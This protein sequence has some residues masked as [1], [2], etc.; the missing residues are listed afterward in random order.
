MKQLLLAL[1]IGVLS[2]GTQ[3]TVLADAWQKIAQKDG[4][5]IS[6]FSQN[7][8][9]SM[10]AT[11]VNQVY[12][13]LDGGSRWTK[14]TQPSSRVDFTYQVHTT[15]DSINREAII[16]LAIKAGK[17]DS[18]YRSR[19]SGESWEIMDWVKDSIGGK[20]P[21]QVFTS[22]F[23]LLYIS[24]FDAVSK[25][26][27]LY[28]SRDNGN[29]F[30]LV[31]TSQKS[32]V[33]ISGYYEAQDSSKYIYSSA[34]VVRIPTNGNRTNTDKNIISLTT[35]QN[36]SGSPVVV[37]AVERTPA[38]SIIRSNNNG[39]SW[40]P[41][42]T[43]LPLDSMKRLV[44]LASGRDGEVYLFFMSN[45]DSTYIYKLGAG[46]SNWQD[47]T[48]LN[49]SFSGVQSL[50]S[51][52]YLMFGKDG[53]FLGEEGA[54]TWTSSSTGIQA[55][56]LYLAAS[57]DQSSIVSC[58]KSGNIYTTLTTTGTWG[59]ST[60]PLALNTNEDITGIA[61]STKG[62]VMLS[63]KTRGIMVSNDRGFSFVQGKLRS[64]NQ[65]FDGKTGGL[66]SNSS[67]TYFVI[68]QNGFLSSSDGGQTWDLIDD[69]PQWN[70]LVITSMFS[71]D[72]STFLLGTSNGV[73]Q[74]NTQS[75]EL[76][77]IGL[78]GVNATIGVDSDGTI[79]AGTTNNEK[80]RL[81]IHRKRKADASFSEVTSVQ[82]NPDMP[83]Q[84]VVTKAGN[85]YINTGISFVVLPTNATSVTPIR[86]SLQDE[87]VTYVGLETN[88]TL[89]TATALGGVYI[90]TTTVPSS[91]DEDVLP[92][93][94]MSIIPNPVSGICSIQTPEQV[95]SITISSVTGIGTVLNLPVNTTT[96]TTSQLN[97]VQ[98]DVSTLQS[99]VYT[100]TVATKR[101][102]I[103]K[104]FVISR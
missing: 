10:Y 15:I 20:T 64:T 61:T 80:T 63:T 89:I 104:L 102:S 73:Q 87:K 54:R 56:P 12:R 96:D 51:G 93:S 41:V 78:T 8:F 71:T 43:N 28:E 66:C 91:V 99:G 75:K 34:E 57:V 48:T 81:T 69:K 58:D 49:R 35:V 30:S 101:G 44:T 24:G 68:G 50:Q 37:Y 67:G 83:Y 13:S 36:F 77:S 62:V 55:F 31:Y 32:S 92:S 46:S 88:G 97:Q 47:V 52:S 22:R 70:S 84:M 42:N 1:V 27:S 4:G 9:L 103:R 16:V 85:T 33:P 53:V 82:L 5:E 94:L 19:N 6:S 25:T 17:I 26:Y 39:Q 90:D 65:I 72:T 14:L 23:G 7:K 95:V 38:L 100:C 21:D 40:T 2:V 45:Q 11:A 98:V 60:L 86:V 79:V 59:T 3:S 18:I 74:F 76:S 29:S